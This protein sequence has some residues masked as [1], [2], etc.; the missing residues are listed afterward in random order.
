MNELQNPSLRYAWQTDNK[1][2]IPV[3]GTG[4]MAMEA[5]VANSVEPAIRRDRRRFQ[6]LLAS[7]V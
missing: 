2:T 6:R 3:S 7:G 1:L 4:S 5:A